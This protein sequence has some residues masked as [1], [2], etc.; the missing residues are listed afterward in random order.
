MKIL[1][2]SAKIFNSTSEFHLKTKDIC[3]EDGVITKI[4]SNLKFPGATIVQG[5]NLRVSTGWFDLY[6][7][8]REPGNE[9]K[10]SIK[11][12]SQSA[13]LGGFTD[14]AGVS[15][16]NPSLYSSAQI[17]F[18]KNN[19]KGSLVN[20]HPFGTITEKKEGK[21]ITELYD[22]HLAGAL[23]FSDGK[24]YISSPELLKRALLYVKPFGGKIMAYCEDNSLANEG[25]VNEGAVAV[26]LG[27]K[28]R[29]AI[30]EEI[31][32]ERNITLAEYTNS[33]IHFQAI[34]TAR[35]VEIIKAAKKRGV[36]ITCDVQLANLL[37]TDEV[38]HDFDTQ[39][40]VLPVLRTEKDR[41]ALVK[42]VKDG[43]VDTVVSGHT[44]QD[45]ESKDCEFDHAEFG[46]MTLETMGVVL[47][48]QLE[49]VLGEDKIQQLLS[50]SAH[51]LLG[52]NIPTITEGNSVSLTILE[53]KD[54][55][56]E[57]VHIKS[58][59]KN[60]PML[61]AKFSQKVLGIVND[62]QLHV[63]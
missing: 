50:E 3:I 6:T 43:V 20:I 37:Y 59:S 25:M 42:G 40:K 23:A 9:N 41:K 53:D 31:A 12:L 1:I 29:P 33:C 48:Q 24:K 57:K 34:S 52:K 55:I 15:G 13:L 61:G 58:V 11:T 14:L 10:D 21:N 51:V 7:V 30:A 54:W 46:M 8:V 47:Y 22:L 39:Y 44:P 26:S 16:S 49:K 60:N 5:E 56:F 62:G 36:K 17:A 2:Q 27:M 63:N 4:G 35:S 45:N 18:L 32:L 38:L 19:S 28:V